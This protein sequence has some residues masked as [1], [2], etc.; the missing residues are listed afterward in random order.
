MISTT[1]AVIM[2][3]TMFLPNGT[4]LKQTWQIIENTTMQ[5]CMEMNEIFAQGGK[6]AVMIVRC[7][8]KK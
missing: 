1:I 6:N 2:T 8:V 7:E 5:H 4:E 3:A